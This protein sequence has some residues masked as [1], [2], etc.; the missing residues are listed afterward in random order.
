MKRKTIL[1]LMVAIALLVSIALPLASSAVEMD[2]PPQ[3]IINAPAGLAFNDATDFFQAFKIFDVTFTGDNY[4]YV[5][6]PAFEVFD[7][8]PGADSTFSLLDFL[9]DSPTAAEMTDL[10]AA[11][12]AYIYYDGYDPND[13][14]RLVKPVGNVD[15]E[16]TQ[17][18]IDLDVTDGGYGYYLIFHSASLF[19]DDEP[20]VQIVA[21][22]ALTTTNPVAEVTAKTDVPTLKKW[23]VLDDGSYAK[24]EGLSIGDIASFAIEVTLPTTFEG[25]DEENPYVLVVHDMLGV[26]PEFFLG[27]DPEGDDGFVENITVSYWEQGEPT[28]ITAFVIDDDYE[29]TSGPYGFEIEFSFD[30]LQ[31][32]PE[33]YS[34]LIEYSAVV[35]EGIREV[36]KGTNSARIEFS[37]NPYE[38]E[39]GTTPPSVVTIYVTGLDDIMKVDGNTGEHTEGHWFELVDGPDILP[40]TLFMDVMFSPDGKYLALKHWSYPYVTLYDMTSGW[41]IIMPEFDE[42]PPGVVSDMAFSPDGQHFAITHNDTPFVTIYNISSGTPTKTNGP[43]DLPEGVGQSV[44]FSSDGKYL[45]VANQGRP[46]ITIYDMT[47]GIPTKL[48]TPSLPGLQG[49]RFTDGK[50]VTFSPIDDILGII[51][52]DGIKFVDINNGAPVIIDIPNISLPSIAISSFVSITFSPN[53]QYLAL[54]YLSSALNYQP[55]IIYDMTGE[56]P[57]KI[58]DPDVTPS[59]GNIEA[60]SFSPDGKYLVVDAGEYP[61]TTVYDMT[62]GYP[63]KMPDI[64][65]DLDEMQKKWNLRNQGISFSPDGQYVVV[66][67]ADFP[68]A[69]YRTPTPASTTYST[70]L[71]GAEFELYKLTTL[72]T[73]D[74]NGNY[75]NIGDPIPFSEDSFGNLL[76]DGN[77][78]NEDDIFYTLMSDPEVAV[79][80]IGPG[81]YMLRETVATNGYNK[82][83]YDIFFEITLEYDDDTEE[84]VY[85]KKVY[86]DTANTFLITENAPSFDTVFDSINGIF[87]TIYIENYSGTLFPGTG[88]IGTTLFYITSLLLTSELTA[89]TIASTRKRKTTPTA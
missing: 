58:D 43:V 68:L 8:Y 56:F 73:P 71:T 19:D 13:I 77:P 84:W 36:L 20:F 10:A 38:D 67:H 42:P 3:I 31:A 39:T 47:G 48:T 9:N 59:G 83:T 6:V 46:C 29:L 25:Y 2:E 40:N 79:T 24:V 64:D 61:F 22:C 11:L 49:I 12:W 54:K 4:S 65:P 51:Y 18:T 86:F 23:L 70:H 88:G 30:A 14:V 1:S 26:C 87:E 34:I 17:V 62:D 45:A 55:I 50:F 85:V 21:A 35:N 82:L 75:Y 44:A 72:D 41:P 89:Y 52:M 81:L 37:R 80:G 74:T 5:I 78:E 66:A 7:D 57:V 63:R 60:I 53:G 69:V 16:E 15:I 27:Y 32:I 33:G 76:F 28:T